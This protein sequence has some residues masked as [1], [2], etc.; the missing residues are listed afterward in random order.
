MIG[1]QGAKCLATFMIENDHT[2]THLDV[3]RNRIGQDGG[4]AILAA[5]EQ[6]TRI[7]DCQIKYGNPISNKMGRI[8]EREIKANI[9]AV[10]YANKHGS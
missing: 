9:Q 3:T 1:N 2:L 5:L 6:T 10:S 8:L 4:Q 7:V